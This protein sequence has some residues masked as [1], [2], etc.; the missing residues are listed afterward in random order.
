[1]QP[2]SPGDIPLKHA[3]QLPHYSQLKQQQYRRDRRSLVLLL[4]FLALTLVVSLCA[5]ERWI[6]PM[7]WLD[8][9]QQLFVWQL[10]L[11][12]TL[13][14]MLVGASLAMSGTVMQAVFDNPLAEP[15]LL[16]V[17]NGAGV[18]L[19]LTVLLGQGLLPV[20]TLSLS[21]IAGALLITFLLLHFAR[22]HISNTRLLLIGIALGII[23]SAVM[24]WAVYFS[25][26]LDLRQ[27]MYW[28]MGGFSGI[29][30]RHGWLMLALLPL[31]LWLSRQ[32]T[33]LNGL[34]LGEI[35]A[36]QLG[37]PVY[38][39]RTILVL[40]MGVQVGLSVALAGI[41]AFIGLVIPHMLRLCGL[42]DQRYLL[43]GCAL[44]GGG[45]LLLA[46]T[47]ARVALSAA[48]L[49][50]GVVTATLGSPWFIWLLLRNRL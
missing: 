27:L 26:S 41:I 48:E 1:M 15:G 18:A 36:R 31:L 17:A 23:C 20:W 24:T 9:A 44:A 28:M 43:S 16:G 33:V 7:A 40:V 21:A 4:A 50:I 2:L 47:V 38:R 22:R 25:T 49:P 45:V 29:D 34:T 11:P 35:Q 3:T 32:G 13:A 10:R 8:E 5:G 42:T 6:W 39:W 37:I 14:V 30:W 46:D 12:R 19:V